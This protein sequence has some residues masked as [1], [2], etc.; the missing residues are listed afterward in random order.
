MPRKCAQ[1]NMV[2][3]AQGLKYSKFEMALFLAQLAWRST[4]DERM[5]SQDP[6]LTSVTEAQGQIL[7]RWKALMDSEKELAGKEENF[8]PNVK[9]EMAVYEWRY[10]RLEATMDAPQKG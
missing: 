1:D 4:Y 2:P 6:D 8:S 3:E 7:E 5:A 9:R 10:K